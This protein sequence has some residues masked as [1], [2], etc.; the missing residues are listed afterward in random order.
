LEL[1]THEHRAAPSGE[2]F[3]CD[4]CGGCFDGPPHGSGLFLWTRGDEYRV[5][6]P[7]LCEA[8]AMKISVGALV[9]WDSEDEEEE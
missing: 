5:E 7:P 2:Q 1:S 6:E 8:C 4:Q 3:E 9:K